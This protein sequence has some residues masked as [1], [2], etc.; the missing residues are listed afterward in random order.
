[1]PGTP[2]GMVHLDVAPVTSGLAVGSLVAGVVS[3]LVGLL[4]VCIGAVAGR[5]GGVWAAAAF[6]LLGLLTGAGAVVAGLLGM[7]QIRRPAAPPAVRF[8]GRGLAIAGVSCGGT[9]LLINLL[10]LV[11]G[12]LLSLA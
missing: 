5:G 4:V 8:T 7:R 10:G 2:F 3:V 6:A 12:V 9:G 11:L 1:M